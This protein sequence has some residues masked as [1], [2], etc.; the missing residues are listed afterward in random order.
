MDQFEARVQN[1][2]AL[3][4]A[5]VILDG[6]PANREKATSSEE[7]QALDRLDL[8]VSLIVSTL[9]KADPHLITQATLDA[10]NSSC[11]NIIDYVQ[12]WMSGQ[13]IEY[14]TV[15]TQNMLD[16]ALVTLTQVNRLEGNSAD[17]AVESIRRS[18]NGYRLSIDNAKSKLDDEVEA[19][20]TAAEAKAADS[21]TKID[22]LDAD[23]VKLKEQLA[24]LTTTSATLVS[25]QQSEFN[26][27]QVDQQK[28]LDDQ[29]KA[30]ST[31]AKTSVDEIKSQASKDLSGIKDD[32]AEVE[33]ILQLVGEESLIGDFS[34]RSK[35]DKDDANRWRLV[36]FVLL[37]LAVV[38][39]LWIVWDPLKTPVTPALL[40]GKILLAGAFT[41]ISTYTARQSGEHRRSQRN[42]ASMALQLAAIKPYIMSMH[43]EDK[44][45]DL[46]TLVALKLFGKP[47]PQQTG[48]KSKDSQT[49]PADDSQMLFME[50]MISIVVEQLKNR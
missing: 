26:K 35:E 15:H 23:V 16:G 41:G 5:K 32:R 33:R 38:A 45:D 19:I 40:I 49:A 2:E 30:L 1:S 11:A 29:I 31:E 21:T 27:I 44:K 36:T 6:I 46:M 4:Q 47:E 34:L 12:R 43:N 25:T 10:L 13:G 3:R 37:L 17:K 48:K 20:K 42:S 39:A 18:A 24:D 50:K 9:E 28:K 14:I 7:T 8:V 22:N